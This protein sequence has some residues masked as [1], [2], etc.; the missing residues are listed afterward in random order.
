MANVEARLRA[1]RKNGSVSELHVEAKEETRESDFVCYWM[2]KAILNKTASTD[3]TN[4]K[5][6]LAY[7]SIGYLSIEGS[8]EDLLETLKIITATGNHQHTE[9]RM[10]R[11]ANPSGFKIFVF[12]G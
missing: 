10:L 11:C 3:L 1:V 9:I 4:G 6:T 7:P 5:L 12:V 8:P 2:P